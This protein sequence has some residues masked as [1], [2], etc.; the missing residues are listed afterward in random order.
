MQTKQIFVEIILTFC[1]QYLKL[2]W[3]SGSKCRRTIL[4]RPLTNDLCI[5]AR[6]GK[7]YYSKN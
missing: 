5:A 1:V 2:V 6:S 7:M 3:I 4:C